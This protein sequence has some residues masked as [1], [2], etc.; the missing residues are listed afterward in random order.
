MRNVSTSELQVLGAINNSKGDLKLVPVVVNGVVR[1]GVGTVTKNEQ[2]DWICNVYAML[3]TGTESIV[4]V[5][6]VSN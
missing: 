1:Y 4:P 5:P 2:G 6:T 3:L